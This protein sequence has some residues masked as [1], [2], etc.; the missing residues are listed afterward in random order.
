[1]SSE[2]GK[3]KYTRRVIRVIERMNTSWRLTGQRFGNVH[4]SPKRNKKER[5]YSV[6]NGTRWLPIGPR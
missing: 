2:G 4:R 5:M 6:L 1:M 3:G